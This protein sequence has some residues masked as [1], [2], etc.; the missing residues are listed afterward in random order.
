MFSLL[1]HPAAKP[2]CH[3]S[4]TA[5]D[6]VPQA[7]LLRS[8]EAVL[9]STAA[10]GECD[11]LIEAGRIAAIG[12]KLAAPAGARIVSGRNRIAVPGLVNA[13]WHSPMQASVGTSDRLDHKRFMWL[14]QADTAG[15]SLEE[16]EISALLGI[17]QMIRSGTTSVVDHFPEQRFEVEEV[18]AAVAALERSGMR[19]VVALRI[20][21]GEYT[22]IMPDARQATPALT[23]AIAD[24]NP[25]VPRPMAESIGI[26]EEAVARFDR[27]AGRIRVFPAPSNPVRCSDGFLVACH[28]LAE[29]HD[30]GVHCH[31][32]ETETQRRVAQQRYGRSMVEQMR[33]L[34]VL[35][36]RWSNAH[37]NWVSDQDMEL[38]AE[39]RAVATFNP[40]S[41][42]KIG[43]GVPPIPALLRAGVTCAIGTDG[44]STNDNV[45]LQEA[46]QLATMLHRA[47][48]PDRS[49][50]VTAEQALA[51]GTTGG[52]AAMLEPEL[53]RLEAGQKAD[54]VLY[55]LDAPTWVPLNDPLQQLVFGERGGGVRTVIIDGRV[56]LEEGRITGFDEAEVIRE[57]KGLL[58]RSRARNA[59][60]AKIADAFV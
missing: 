45:I 21:D 5:R 4:K 8:V 9:G 53:G 7:L 56:V 31:L 28:E 40:E 15:R 51:I 14:N 35:D 16:I 47:S 54:L 2:G 13:H 39:A 6:P 60:I 23:A 37:C 24:H 3:M 43:S 22:D 29:R 57:A 58:A 38:M 20:F 52:A 18:G 12:A 25:L 36:R 41:N 32:L 26:V 27:T 34:G 50:W 55:D 49:R 59:G 44:A 33:A 19:G 48:E 10:T 30:L 42:L 46:L 11:I 17:I 1:S